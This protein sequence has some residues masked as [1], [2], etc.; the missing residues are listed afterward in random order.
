MVRS[1]RLLL[2][3]LGTGMVA[4]RLLFAQAPKVMTVAVLFPGDSDDD[5]AAARPFFAE[6]ERHGW[7]EG[8]N[9]A[10]DRHA[11]KGARAYL[12]SLV[13]TAVGRTPD[14]IFATTASLAAAT[15][16]ETKTVPV[17]FTTASDPVAGGLVASLAKPGGNATGVYHVPGDA[18]AKRY[19]LA[20]QLL[21]AQVKR[22]GSVWDRNV[23]DWQSRKASHEKAARGAGFELAATEFTNFEAVAKLFA[24]YKRDGVTAVEITPSFA[25]IGRRKEV[26]GLAE[27]NGI[28]LVAHRAEWADAGAVLTF[29]ADIAQSYR[30]AAVIV[31]RVLKGQ[32][33]AAI[34]VERANRHELVLN[35]RA[36]TT[37]GLSIPKGLQQQA[38]RVIT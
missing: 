26:A 12:E 29:G 16:K 31:H 35:Q 33:P 10:Y 17:V 23:L 18:A 5:E 32:N 30:R 21:P 4:P 15:L 2:A 11:S 20:R 7:Q 27:R 34:H 19:A 25:L 24:Q 28:A 37:L 8:K 22:L 6:M 36:A 38:S 3:M 13:G 14:L 9:I 1:R